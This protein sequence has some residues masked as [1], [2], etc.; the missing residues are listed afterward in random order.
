MDDLFALRMIVAGMALA[1][2]KV[3]RHRGHLS[4]PEVSGDAMVLA[5]TQGATIVSTSEG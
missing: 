2:F 3:E 5:V 1:G 4:E